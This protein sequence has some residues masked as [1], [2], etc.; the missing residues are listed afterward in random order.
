MATAACKAVKTQYP[1][2]KL[3][4]ITGYPEVFLCNPNV[5]RVFRHGDINYFYEENIERRIK[6]LQQFVEGESIGIPPQI[7]VYYSQ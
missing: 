1:K 2:S 6:G 7:G 4:V 5:D 3:I